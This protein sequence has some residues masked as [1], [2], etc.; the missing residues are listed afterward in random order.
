MNFRKI[1]S[2]IREIDILLAEH[3]KA[4]SAADGSMPDDQKAA[5]D[6]LVSKVN[7][8]VKAL[9]KAL[10]DFKDFPSH[11]GSTKD[12][13]W[14]KLVEKMTSYRQAKLKLMDFDQPGGFEKHKKEKALKEKWE[15]EGTATLTP[16]AAPKAEEKGSKESYTGPERRLKPRSEL[17]ASVDSDMFKVNM[18]L[19][20]SAVLAADGPTSVFEDVAHFYRK[21][22][23]AAAN[24][25][26]KSALRA[27]VKALDAAIEAFKVGPDDQRVHNSLVKALSNYKRAAAEFFR[28]EL[29]RQY[30]T[31]QG[32]RMQSGRPTTFWKDRAP[33]PLAPFS[34]DLASE[35][36]TM[37]KVAEAYEE[38]EKLL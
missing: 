16:K 31:Q 11:T 20:S 15:R 30:R 38:I 34:V 5:R 36:A 27:E 17:K 18:L 21:G 7:E 14:E 19:A 4:V 32:E 8:E 23:K 37:A 26:L 22:K 2:T 12:G 6:A 33:T 13:N 3:E 10:K 24:L 25:K 29:R 35:K 28:Q 9:D 1:E